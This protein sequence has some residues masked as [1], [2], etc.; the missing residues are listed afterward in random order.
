MAVAIGSGITAW[1]KTGRILPHLSTPYQPRAVS[2][3][4]IKAK[5]AIR[6]RVAWVW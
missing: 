1:E 3:V 6:P 4:I 5:P 2:S